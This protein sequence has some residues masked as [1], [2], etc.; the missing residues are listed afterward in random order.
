MAGTDSPTFNDKGADIVFLSSDEPEPVRFHIHSINLKVSTGAFP[1]LTMGYSAGGIVGLTVDEPVKLSESAR[2]LEVLFAFMYPRHHPDL[3]DMPFEELAPLAE[4]IEKYQVFPA[5]HVC[6]P[7]MK[8]FMKDQPVQ[9]GLWAERHG[10]TVILDQAAPWTISLPLFKALKVLPDHLILSWAEYQSNWEK[11]KDVFLYY[12]DPD[13]SDHQNIR[14]SPVESKDCIS[15]WAS[16]TFPIITRLR[17]GL[18]AGQN[19]FL[20]LDKLFSSPPREVTRNCCRRAVVK[21]R[22]SVETAI[23]G[24]PKFS[25]IVRRSAVGLDEENE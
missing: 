6:K 8:G 23:N 16:I 13:D 12:Q 24:L 3:E 17:G 11:V 4:A 9:V 22:K 25:Q 21:W 14:S 19:P 20:D 7:K 1:P 2:V 10:H 5:M 18:Q 15:A